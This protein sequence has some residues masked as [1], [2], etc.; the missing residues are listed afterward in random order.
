[1]RKII[2]TSPLGEIIMAGVAASVATMF[3]KEAVVLFLGVALSIY[4]LI[5]VSIVLYDACYQ[6]RG[7]ANAAQSDEGKAK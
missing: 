3:L 7:A 6:Q 1:M 4:M 5:S 2:F